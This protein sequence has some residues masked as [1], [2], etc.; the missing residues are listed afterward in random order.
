MNK[1][2]YITKENDI[3][4]CLKFLIIK[5]NRCTFGAGSRK[6]KK[7]YAELNKPSIRQ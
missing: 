1:T 3:K 2:D 7:C 4:N 5:W 6:K